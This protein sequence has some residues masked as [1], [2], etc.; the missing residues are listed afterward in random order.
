MLISSS[1]FKMV[2]M[3][4]RMK[5]GIQYAVVAIAFSA[6]IWISQNVEFSAWAEESDESK[7]AYNFTTIAGDEI[8]N[9]P[10]AQK[11][12]KNIE[13]AK[14]RVEQ[15]QQKQKQFIEQQKFIEEQ[16]KIAKESLEKQLARMNK[17]Y[18]GFTPKNSYARFLSNNI[19]ATHHDIFWDQF[20]SMNERV[21]IA[22]L[23]KKAVLDNGGTM[24]EAREEFNKYAA[25]SR[26]EM[27]NYVMELNIKYGFTD[28]ELQSYFDE[29]GKL[30]RYEN[31]GDASCYGCDKYEK[32]KEQILAEKEHA[33]TNKA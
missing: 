33:K 19:N 10:M 13:I 12:L 18:E 2:L 31:D 4:S 24:K 11:I 22:S 1:L 8:K 21:K 6:L 26:V 17:D 7:K 5:L 15:I 14:Q 28:K 20:N 30:P 29:Y 16:R 3:N 23:A 9:N 32:I 25:M 27:I